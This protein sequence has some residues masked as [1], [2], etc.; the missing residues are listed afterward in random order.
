MSIITVSHR[1]NLSSQISPVD[2]EGNSHKDKCIK[3]NG[4]LEIKTLL[5]TNEVSTLMIQ[6]PLNSAVSWGPS[7]Q[8]MSLFGGNYIS[9]NNRALNHHLKNPC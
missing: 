9:N 6:L 7:L 1:T 3:E 4:Q 8:H 2:H 5:D